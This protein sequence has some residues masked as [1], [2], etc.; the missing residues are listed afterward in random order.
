VRA[1]RVEE[2]RTAHAV[3]TLSHLVARSDFALYRERA[4][5][6]REVFP[7]LRMLL[8]GPWPPYSF[9]V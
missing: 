4:R 3:L 9:A 1:E 5:Q 8:S 2:S 7:E 6:I